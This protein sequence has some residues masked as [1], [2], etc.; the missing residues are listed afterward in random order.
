MFNRF[1]ASKGPTPSATLVPEMS[2][3]AIDSALEAESGLA[4]L[5]LRVALHQRMIDKINL[6][7]LETMTR[8]E[9]AEQI[10][11][12]VSKLLVEERAVLNSHEYDRLL[13]E[14]L[15]EVLGLG[16]LEPLLKDP[17]IAD[18]LVNTHR[19]V[20]VERSGKLERTAVQFKD[21]KHLTRIIQKIVSAVGRRVDES[22]PWVD[23]RLADGSR[24]NALL[25]PCAVDGPLLSIRKFSK[26]PYNIPRLIENGSVTEQLAEILEI[27][28]KS[29]LN[30]LISGGTG[31]GKTTIL[32]AMSSLISNRERIVTI[33][34]TAELQL[35]Q[36]HIAR[37]ESR[38]ANMEGVGQ[39]SQRDLLR[40]SLRMR[41]DRIVVGEVRGA[42]VVDML[43]AMNTGHDG[44]MTTI[45]ANTA[46]DALTR[47]E[48]MVAMAGFDIPVK[49]LRGQIASAIQIVVQLQ[50]FG[51]GRRRVVSVQEITG[52]EGDVISMQEI[53]KFERRGV[54]A[55]ENVIG[56]HVPTGIRPRFAQRAREYGFDMPEHLFRV[57]P[58][59][60]LA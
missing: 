58:E 43:Q 40:N 21:N 26:I 49:A 56:R 47:L 7:A 37:M 14:I 18:I 24:V 25:P 5:N 23:A 39:V 19:Q 20:F 4:T 51:D 36:E 10:R 13:D 6:H 11:P 41:P 30:V 59:G 1:H 15:D 52:L 29:R 8:A 12:L 31:T 38:P 46:R 60:V 35:Q 44:S 45:H 22:Q 34:D 9:V 27:I 50:R 42:E 57:A 17:T 32:N 53:Y 28:V 33:E 16:P 54:D 48:N 55:N 2:S 3:P